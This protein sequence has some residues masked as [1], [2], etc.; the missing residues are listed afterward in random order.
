VTNR[1]LAEKINEKGL[2]GVG[3]WCIVTDDIER[4]LDE[5]DAELAKAEERFKK[6]TDGWMSDW[7]KANNA[8]IKERDK[9]RSLAGELA[10]ALEEFVGAIKTDRH[11]TNQ[12]HCYKVGC[13]AIA[14][15]REVGL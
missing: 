2:L 13:E 5:K 3:T 12:W 6:A 7:E 14:K 15:A 10:M 11:V 1:E 4:A 8:L 9:W